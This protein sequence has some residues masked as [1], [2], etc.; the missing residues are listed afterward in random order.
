MDV[1]KEDVQMVGVAEEDVREVQCWL[2]W[3][4]RQVLECNGLALHLV[5][6]A[7]QGQVDFHFLCDVLVLVGRSLKHDG[8]LSVHV[9]LGKLPVRLPRLSPEDDLDVVWGPNTQSSLLFKK[10]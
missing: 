9:C 8:D 5:W 3:I 2:T 6:D 1:V 4:A 7:T 10:H